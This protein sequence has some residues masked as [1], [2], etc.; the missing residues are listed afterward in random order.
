MSTV[1]KW[2]RWKHLL[3]NHQYTIHNK[4]RRMNELVKV[5]GSIEWWSENQ[6][7][8]SLIKEIPNIK[9]R[10]LLLEKYKE[11]SGKNFRYLF[12]IDAP[13]DVNDNWFY[14]DDKVWVVTPLALRSLIENQTLTTDKPC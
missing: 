9:E 6:K 13:M 5:G 4:K 3:L 2:K 8:K 14:P 11:I 7:I 10:N 12:I 1:Q